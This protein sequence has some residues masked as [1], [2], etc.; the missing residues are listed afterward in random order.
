MAY[1]PLQTLINK[2]DFSEIVRD[3]IGLILV[4]EVANQMALA[5]AATEDPALW[6]LKIYLERHN[7]IE[8][9]LN[10]DIETAT[11]SELAPVV[12]ISYDAASVDLSQSDHIETQ[13]YIGTFNIDVYAMGLSQDQVTGHIPSDKDSSYKVQAAVRLVRNILM[14]STNIQLQLPEI[15]HD[16]M[17]QSMTMQPLAPEV[18]GV[19]QISGA[20]LVFEVGY[21]ELSPQFV[22]GT[23]EEI[24]LKLCRAE[25]GSLLSEM[26]FDYT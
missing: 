1:V 2:Q 14:A 8:D 24:N 16:R 6:D 7:P 26:T 13:K 3:Q 9:W 20:R 22:G 25:D 17:I 21:R 12:N 4:D 18:V 11:L 23:L 19:Q 5:I 15:V 10:P